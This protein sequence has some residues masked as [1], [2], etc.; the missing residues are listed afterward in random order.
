MVIILEHERTHRKAPIETSLSDRGN[1]EVDLL[2]GTY[3]V[4]SG[5]A[6]ELA[7]ASRRELRLNHF[8]TCPN[9]PAWRSR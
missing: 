2:E 1:I 3:R 9:A 7:R 4:V 5:A 6:L 8:A